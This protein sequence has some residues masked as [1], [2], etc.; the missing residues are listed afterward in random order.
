MLIDLVIFLYGETMWNLITYKDTC[1]VLSHGAVFTKYIQY[2]E[3]DYV[4]N[5][6]VFHLSGG[7]TVNVDCATKGLS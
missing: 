3:K 1:I 2:L 7:K 4:S 6:V 5:K